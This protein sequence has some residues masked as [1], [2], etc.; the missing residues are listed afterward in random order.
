M[1]YVLI[2]EKNVEIFTEEFETAEEAIKEGE[3]K[4]GSLS[5]YDK[6]KHHAF[7]VIESVN[8]DEEAVNH[9]DGTPVKIRK[10]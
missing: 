2:N 8:P 4:W 10:R 9:L 3:N 6:K 7:Y 5:A 1:K